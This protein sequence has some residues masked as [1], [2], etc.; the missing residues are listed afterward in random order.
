MSLLN[1]LWTTLAASSPRLITS[2]LV[3]LRAHTTTSA[4]KLQE[5]L[6][7]ADQ[8]LLGRASFSWREPNPAP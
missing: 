5:D 3:D 7:A 8:L 2:K 4:V 1:A 6:S